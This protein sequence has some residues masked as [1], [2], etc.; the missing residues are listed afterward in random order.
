MQD[1]DRRVVAVL[2]TDGDPLVHAAYPDKPP[3]ID[4]VGGSDQHISGGLALSYR[5]PAKAHGY[6]EDQKAQ[7]RQE[8]SQNEFLHQQIERDPLE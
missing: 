2:A 7:E 3:L 6:R 8:S 5:A 4:S 1:E